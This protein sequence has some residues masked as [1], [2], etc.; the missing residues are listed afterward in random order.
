MFLAEAS[1]VELPGRGGA[2]Q[3]GECTFVHRARHVAAAGEPDLRLHLHTWLSDSGLA[4]SQSR[5]A[6]AG[7]WPTG[8]SNRLSEIGEPRVRVDG[9]GRA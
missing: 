7:S 6:A 4:S 8:P 5:T 3:A 2:A 1:A 9:I